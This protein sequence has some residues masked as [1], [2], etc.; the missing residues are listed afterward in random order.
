M[1]ADA[2][3][4]TA[5][6]LNLLPHLPER[7]HSQKLSGLVHDLDLPG[8][9]PCCS[10]LV[11]SRRP[12]LHLKIGRL[13]VVD[14]GQKKRILP[15]RVKATY[16]RRIYI[17]HFHP[18]TQTSSTCSSDG[19]GNLSVRARSSYCSGGLP[20]WRKCRCSIFVSFAA[21]YLIS[22][23]DSPSL[24]RILRQEKLEMALRYVDNVAFPVV[25]TKR[26]SS[27]WTA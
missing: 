16:L 3:T 27:P 6:S 26:R 20:R 13:K 22:E 12:D 19:R 24:Q 23:G 8:H 14:E 10:E 17:L 25:V 2:G 7:E 4:K 5:W 9:H 18:R 1:F 15:F 21:I 11:G